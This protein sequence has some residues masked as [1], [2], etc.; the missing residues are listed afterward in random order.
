MADSNED[1]PVIRKPSIKVVDEQ[2]RE[3][4]RPDIIQTVTQLGSLA[5][6]VRIR[7]SLEREQVYGL[8]DSR[9]LSASDVQDFT[10]LLEVAPYTSLATATFVNDGPDSVYLAI[11]R[12]RPFHL[13]KK[14]ESVPADFTKADQR[15]NY[16]EYYC[17]SGETASIR[18]LGK[19]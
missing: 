15:I 9:T 16:L 17:D 19:Y 5:Q 11:N 4:V 12:S 1:L 8:T 7:R 14:G 13:L 2:G 10:N 3:I 18:V 6:L